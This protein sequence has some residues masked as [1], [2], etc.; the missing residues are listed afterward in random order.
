MSRRRVTERHPSPRQE[1]SVE[2]GYEMTDAS[3]K[4]IFIV[5]VAALFVGFLIHVSLWGIFLAFKRDAASTYPRRSALTPK[6]ELPPEPRLQ[7]NPQDDLLQMRRENSQALSSTGWVDKKAG[8]A[9]IPI[10]DAMQIFL[11]EQR[12]KRQ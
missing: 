7:L 10:E 9:R 8:I 3:S 4:G 6:N 2:A 11:A 5:G 12:R 1:A